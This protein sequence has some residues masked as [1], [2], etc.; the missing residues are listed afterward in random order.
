MDLDIYGVIKVY[1]IYSAYT[2]LKLSS[3]FDHILD[4][5]G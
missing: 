1:I 3:D 4:D 5:S 2:T